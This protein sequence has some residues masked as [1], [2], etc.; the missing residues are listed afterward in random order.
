[1]SCNC[2][3]RSKG[4]A[5]RKLIQL[6]AGNNDMDKLVSEL[7]TQVGALRGLLDGLVMRMWESD[8]VYHLPA[9]VVENVENALAEFDSKE[10]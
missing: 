5:R 6:D 4:E 2:F 10:D 7:S 1:M 9:E 3:A 8:G